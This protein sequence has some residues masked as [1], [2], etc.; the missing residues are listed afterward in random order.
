MNQRHLCN[1][2]SHHEKFRQFRYTK[3]A[4]TYNHQI[5]AFYCQE[6]T[7]KSLKNTLHILRY[8]PK[9]TSQAKG[10]LNSEKIKPVALAVIKLCLTEGIN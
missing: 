5:N 7:G 8:M 9:G 3:E 4:I 2:G 10:T 6:D 1:Q